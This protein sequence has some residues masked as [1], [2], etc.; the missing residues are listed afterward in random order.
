MKQK[1]LYVCRECG[2][3]SVKWYGKCP[4]CLE[5]NTLEEREQR[6]IMPVRPALAGASAASE[7]RLMSDIEFADGENRSTT[8]IAELD[9]VLGGGLVEGSVV[10]VGGDPGIGK[11]TLLLQVCAAM[12]VFKKVL[13]VSGEES[14]SQLK[15][16]AKRLGFGGS[17][18]LVLSQTNMAD[19]SSAIEKNAPDIVVIDSIQT[20]FRPE[21]PSAPGS[22]SQIRE[23]AMQLMQIAKSGAVTVLIVGHV[24]KEG[25][26]AGPKILEHMVDCV[27]YFEGDR[28]LSYRIL[29]AVKNRFGS[30]NEIGVFEMGNDGLREVKNPSMMLIEGRPSQVSGNCVACVIEGSRPMLTEVQALVSPGYGGPHRRMCSGVDYSRA[31]M[32]M[33]VLEKRCGAVLSNQDVYLNVVGGLRIDEP[34]ADLAQALAIV[35]SY[36]DKPV[37][38]DIVAI[39]EIGLTGEIRAVSQTDLRIDEAVRLGFKKILIPALGKAPAK[40]ADDVEI[41]RAKTLAQAIALVF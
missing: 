5:W 30:T 20:V 16:R 14:C 29:R 7:P 3:E 13:Y 24:T 19:I 17:D 4:S 41:Y 1:T 23:C 21:L 11:S 8:K 34:A 38:D 39:G 10:L 2:Y 27:L 12:S 35:S 28:H 22:A 6:D 31:S 36:R 25:A 32:V 9:R 33:A 15:M 40:R 18:M 37:R 26:I